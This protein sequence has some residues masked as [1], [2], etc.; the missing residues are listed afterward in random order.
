MNNK[1]P[2]KDDLPE[3]TVNNIRSILSNNGFFVHEEAWFENIGN[4]YSCMITTTDKRIHGIGKG[5]SRSYALASAYGEL[6]ERLQSYIFFNKLDYPKSIIEKEGFTFDPEEIKYLNIKE[7]PEIPE[8][9]KKSKPFLSNENLF[10]SWNYTKKNLINCDNLQHYSF[11]PYFNIK[12]KS[13]VYLPY[14]FLVKI[15]KSNG[16]SAGNT[17]E[18][19]LVQ[20]ISEILERYIQK[21][22]YF[23]GYEPPIISNE[24]L[25]KIN[26]PIYET[27]V[28]IENKTKNKIFFRDCSLEKKIPVICMVIIDVTSNKYSVKFASDPDISIAFER[29]L[30][31]YYQ[32]IDN[33]DTIKLN[34]ININQQI[35]TTDN[36]HRATNSGNGYFPDCLLFNTD[37]VSNININNFTSYKEKLDYFINLINDLGYSDIYIRD[38]SF[39]GFPSNQIIIPGLSEKGVYKDFSELMPIIYNN[40]FSII[41]KLNST[42][43][44]EGYINIISYLEHIYKYRDF[45]DTSYI[46]ELIHIEATN[47]NWL[48]YTIEFVL[49]LLYFLIKDYN[50]SFK[51]MSLH[52][53]HLETKYSSSNLEFFLCSKNYLNF[54]I[55]DEDSESIIKKLENIH[56]KEVLNTVI[57][58][59]YN[60]NLGD[61]IKSVNIP[62]YCE[63][64][65]SFYLKLK[66]INKNTIINQRE[67]EYVFY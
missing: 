57:D 52:L 17:K 33:N 45:N 15:F 27:I 30:T 29:C 46:F 42:I 24:C 54:L 64:H 40:A 56:N 34:D 49:S 8:S 60:L 51:Y 4:L 55:I 18:E 7:L 58:F 61:I 41:E 43:D 25:K 19:S 20:G 44:N 66:E 14:Y 39:L 2:Y 31:E 65:S 63:K 16:M 47:N 9:F 10:D 32:G 36:Y 6:I 53:S 5:L 59:F 35:L 37:M 67:L 26:T 38:N 11:I 50:K 23:N 13:V 22:I 21:Q 48:N 12:D 1:C 28:Q 62:S 3:S